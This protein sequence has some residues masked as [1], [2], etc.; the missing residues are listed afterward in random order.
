MLFLKTPCFTEVAHGLGIKT[1]SMERQ[2]PALKEHYAAIEEGKADI[3]V[4]I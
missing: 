3:L 1:P 4:Y 2:G